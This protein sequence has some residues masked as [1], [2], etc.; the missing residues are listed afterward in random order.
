MFPKKAMVNL[1]LLSEAF[2]LYQEQIV[3]R[4]QSTSTEE[5]HWLAFRSLSSFIGDIEIGNL[6]FV[7]VR[8]W[9]LALEKKKLS[10]ATIRGYIIRLRVVL[11]F[12]ALK[13]IETLKPDEVPV[14]KRIDKV[15]AYISKEKVQL[16][17]DESSKERHILS[18]LRNQSIISLLYASGIRISELCSLDINDLHD[19]SFTVIG[20]GGKA[21]LCFYD[22]RTEELLKR[23]ISIRRNG[24][25]VYINKGGVKTNS[26]R[27]FHEPD[28][29]PALFINQLGLRV[30][31]NDIQ[32][33]FRRVCKKAGLDER[34]TPHT[35][36]HSFATELLKENTNL[37]YV[38]GFL[39]HASLQT[40]Q[41]Y[42]HIVDEDLRAIYS[43][44]H[45]I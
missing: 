18:A 28:N 42:T 9:K 25:K 22:E 29:N 8:D 4:N 19:Q 38:Q 2:N 32:I 36:R 21:R 27:Y 3:F 14:P 23:Y 43:V 10:P 30:N 7:K 11:D 31:P 6:T 44:K 34:V 20:K 26:V 15:P 35:L 33:M 12:L 45:K 41:M 1:M 16:L 37:R 5:H 17:I 24:Y 39:G 13:G 40:T